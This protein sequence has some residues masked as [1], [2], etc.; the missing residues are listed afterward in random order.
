MNGIV[1]IVGI[2]YLI[3]GYIQV[4]LKVKLRSFEISEILF[5]Y[6]LLHLFLC[7]LQRITFAGKYG[8]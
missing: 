5:Y 7:C 4:A 2:A 1:V 8:A 3:S 6:V